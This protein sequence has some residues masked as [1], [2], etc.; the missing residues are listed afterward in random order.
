MLAGARKQKASRHG[1]RR[2][3]RF[4]QEFGR[5]DA[6]AMRRLMARIAELDLSS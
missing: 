4:E 5:D 1:G 3:L 6:L 2:K